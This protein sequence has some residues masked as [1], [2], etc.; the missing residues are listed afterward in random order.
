MTVQDLPKRLFTL[1][2]AAHV[3]SMGRTRLFAEIRTGR[4]A[5]VGTGKNRRVTADAID[6]YINLLKTEVDAA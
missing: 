3:L 4:L 6:A 2:E 5:T 1:T